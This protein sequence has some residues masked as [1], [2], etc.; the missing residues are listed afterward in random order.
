MNSWLPF[1]W[2]VAL[3]FLREGR[4]QTVFITLGVTIGVGVIVFMSA[5]LV[6]MQGNLFRRVLS[7]QPHITLERP[8]QQAIQVVPPQPGQ[9]ITP[10]LQKPAQRMNTVDQWQKVRDQMQAR[11]DVVAV[12]PIASG[13]ALVVR[14]SANQAITLVGIEPDQYIK[15]V[16]LP[17]KMLSGTFRMT[18]TEMIIGTQLAEDMGVRLGDKLR[19]TTAAGASL[20]LTIAGTFDLGSR[21][22][23]Q[24]TVY[25][26][27]STAQNLLNMVGGVSGID[28]TV[29]DPYEAEIIAASIA[30]A[31]GLNATS[32]IAANNQFFLAMHAQTY[33]SLVIRIFVALSVAA[34]IASVLVVSVVQRQKEVGILRAMGGSRGQ[35][36]RIFLIQ[37]AVVG[38]IGSLLGSTLATGL[39]A[40]WRLVARNPDGTPMFMITMDASFFVWSALIATLSGLL[41]AVT[42]ALRAAH[43]DPVVAI[44][45]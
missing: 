4:M 14:G 25:A 27:L 35:I 22:A 43:L 2:I 20:T 9:I 11:G 38:L 18:N 33:S 30:N 10:A 26:L 19:V 34:G 3:R 29:G 37:G 21:S 44:R 40:A 42:P 41:A 1:E 12:S 45:G 31:T 8:K 36:M 28:L 13:P 39:L 6:G 17:E 5:V 23:N 24:R 7:S 16:P 15:I 32:W